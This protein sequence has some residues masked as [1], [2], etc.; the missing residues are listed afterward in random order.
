MNRL[1][2][3]YLGIR[4][5]K[6]DSLR[7][8]CYFKLHGPQSQLPIVNNCSYC[9]LLLEFLHDSL[10][11]FLNRYTTKIEMS[12]WKYVYLFILYWYFVGSI[13]P[14]ISQFFCLLDKLSEDISVSHKPIAK[15]RRF[16][17]Q[18]PIKNHPTVYNQDDFQNSVVQITP[19]MA[20]IKVFHCSGSN[21]FTPFK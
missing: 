15:K 6:I 16:T 9:F 10:T 21:I 11:D 17:C 4:S 5:F 7:I 13:A 3:I 18:T 2:S 12:L 20:D 19:K 1:T 8:H 14:K